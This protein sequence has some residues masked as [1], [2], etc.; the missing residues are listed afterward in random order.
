MSLFA[1]LEAL[2]S[3]APDAERVAFLKTQAFAHRGLHGRGLVENSLP[4]FEAAVAAGY[5]NECDV[6]ASLDG[7]A[8][9]FHDE[10]LDRLTA[11]KGL[12][13]ERTASLLDAVILS[14]AQTPLPRLDALLQAIGGRTPLLIEIKAPDRAVNRACR[15]ARR[16]LEGY[17][18]PVAVM[19][20]NPLVGR[21]FR[22]QAPAIVRGLV[23]TEAEKSVWRGRCERTLALWQ[24]KPDFLAYDV[25]NLPSLFAIRARRRGVPVLTWTV[26]NAVQ[27]ATALSQADESIFEIP[28][29]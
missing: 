19:S 23:I 4:A 28:D 18:G 16:A 26:R 12:L 25:A 7:V 2:L 13:K 24:A 15:A 5:G 17:R 10:R 27:E 22:R 1:R 11:E 3:P 14:G 6:Q 9:V 29:A 20:F 8:F 21:W